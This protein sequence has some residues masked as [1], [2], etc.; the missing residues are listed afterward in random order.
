MIAEVIGLYTVIPIVCIVA[1][2]FIIGINNLIDEFQ[3]T[4][5]HLESHHRV[6]QKTVAKVMSLSAYRI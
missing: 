4:G 2:V 6:V 5:F 3:A 1:Y